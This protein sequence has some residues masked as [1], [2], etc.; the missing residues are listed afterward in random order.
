MPE[1]SMSVRWPDG[2]LERCYSPSR[3][4]KDYFQAGESY[5]IADFRARSRAALEAASDRVRAKFGFAC[6][7]AREELARIE[8]RCRSYADVPD[9]RVRIE[10]FH[11]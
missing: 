9:A 11:E 5:G 8:S 1:V 7:R 2:S 4:V 6:R 10:A 3:V